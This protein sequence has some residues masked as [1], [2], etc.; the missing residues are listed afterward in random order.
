[1]PVGRGIVPPVKT[2][3]KAAVLLLA[4]TAWVAA[5]EA[6]EP[7]TFESYPVTLADPAAQQEIVRSL[8][9]TN[10]TVALDAAGT[11]L[12]VV[13]T[14]DLHAQIRAMLE[15]AAAP[16]VNIRID[17]RF[18]GRRQQSEAEAGAEFSGGI[19]R[20]EGLTHTTL[21]VRPQLRDTS[22]RSVSDTVQTLVVASGR[23]GSLEVSESVPYVEWLMDWG[24][25]GGAIIRR[26]NWQSVG[27]FLVVQP[28]LVGDGPMINIRLTPELSGLVDGSPYRTRFAGVATEVVVQDGQPFRIGGLG[29]HEEFYSRFLVGG[30]GAESAESVEIELTPRILRPP[31]K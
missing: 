25:R 8:V 15:E 4:C 10:G 22:S 23:E 1:M 14:A 16:P 30:A 6:G 29:S 18:R 27:S 5:Q 24:V 2:L 7:N 17:V 12:L 21:R 9:G 19:E 31:A 13:T 11:R 26:L 28:T 20:E 3:H